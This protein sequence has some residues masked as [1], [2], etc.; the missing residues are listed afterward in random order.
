[1][2]RLWQ[3]LFEKNAT[4]TAPTCPYRRETLLM[5]PVLKELHEETPPQ[6]PHELSHRFEALQM[7]QV[8][9]SLFTKQQH[10]DALQEVRAEV[11]RREGSNSGGEGGSG[12]KTEVVSS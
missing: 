6:D 10:A 7:R 12:F 3:E 1:M 11:R 2:Q 8:R 5:H 9:T 4:E